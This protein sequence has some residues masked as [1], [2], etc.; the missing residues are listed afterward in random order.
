[1]PGFDIPSKGQFFS[2]QPVWWFWPFGIIFFLNQRKIILVK[3]TPKA[4]STNIFSIPLLITHSALNL[5]SLLHFV[6][7][8]IMFSHS[9][10]SFFLCC[11]CFTPLVPMAFILFSFCTSLLCSPQ[12]L[13]QKVS[14][15]LS[16]F[17]SNSPP[18]FSF[19][20]LYFQHDYVS[21]HSL[22][23]SLSACMYVEKMIPHFIALFQLHIASSPWSPYLT[24]CVPRSYAV[25]NKSLCWKLLA[26]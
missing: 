24:H 14:C 3:K 17:P 26:T 7:V 2:R 4:T 23:C 6:Y 9:F 1:M 11:L 5:P 16:L 13:Q 21:L 10:F 15:S 22:T 25:I 20:S 19:S 8:H 12:F 18:L